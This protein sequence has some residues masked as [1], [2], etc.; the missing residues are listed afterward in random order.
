[1]E[2]TSIKTLFVTVVFSLIAFVIVPIY[3]EAAGRESAAEI[4][5][6]TGGAFYDSAISGSNGPLTR[7]DATLFFTRRF[8]LE[9][10]Y[11]KSYSELSSSAPSVSMY[12]ASGVYNFSI[13]NRVVP[14]LIVGLGRGDFLTDRV[15]SDFTIVNSGGGIKYFFS[16]DFGLR[17]DIRDYVTTTDF[18]NNFTVTL[19]L[20]YVIGTYPPEK[21]KVEEMRVVKKEK[22]EKQEEFLPPQRPSSIEE[23]EMYEAE[24]LPGPSPEYLA[25]MEEIK[26]KL[27][28]KKEEKKAKE[29]KTGA[30]AIEVAKAEEVSKTVPEQMEAQEEQIRKGTVSVPEEKISEKPEVEGPSGDIPP[31]G[32]TL[33]VAMV[34][35]EPLKTENETVEAIGAKETT[36]MSAQPEVTAQAEAMSPEKAVV[37]T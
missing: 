30:V 20:T 34:E 4:H 6:S 14:Y 19:G 27:Q 9:M 16:K 28:M 23:E 7:V 18:N 8:A 31:E 25:L 17:F 15:T 13:N 24:E 3:A 33:E 32:E 22:K 29:G 2:K 10:S 11:F 26:K 36:E 5:F 37:V 35:G 1:M 21:P 12:S